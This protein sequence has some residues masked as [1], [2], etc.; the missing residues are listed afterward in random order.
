MSPLD[1][2]GGSG[3]WD[4]SLGFCYL[5]LCWLWCSCFLPIDVTRHAHTSLFFEAGGGF[6]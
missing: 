3:S 4:F 2:E 1:F 5:F 6:Q